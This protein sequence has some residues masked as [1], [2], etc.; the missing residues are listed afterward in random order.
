MTI[1][2]GNSEV[3]NIAIIEPYSAA[4]AGATDYDEKTYYPDWVRPDDW[5]DMPVINSGDNK[6]AILLAVE[7]GAIL[8][9]EVGLMVRGTGNNTLS[10]INWGDGNTTQVEK[11]SA[12]DNS[13]TYHTY[14]FNDLPSSTEIQFRDTVARQ[15]IIEIDNSASGLHWLWLDQMNDGSISSNQYNTMLD[16]YVDG[17]DVRHVRMG[18][19]QSRFLKRLEI[20]CGDGTIDENPFQHLEDLRVAYLPSGA[21]SHR[22][23]INNFFKGCYTLESAPMLD[24]SSCTSTQGIFWDCR[25]LRSVP[26]YDTSNSTNFYTCFYG[27]WSLKNI[28]N[29]DFS[30][31][32]NF[33]YIFRDC[34]D[35]K[36]V[37]YGI[38]WPTGTYNLSR[39]F[40]GCSELVYVANDF[41]ISGATNLEE[42]F[43]SCISLKSVPDIYAP[44]ATSMR[45]AF[46]RCQSLQKINLKDISSVTNMYYC[47][48]DC[49][50][51]IEVKGGNMPTGVTNYFALFHE[52]PKIVKT[53]EFPTPNAT[54]ISYMFN[55]CTNLETTQTFDMSNVVDMYNLYAGCVKIKNDNLKFI[56]FNTKVNRAQNAFNGCYALTSIPSGLFRDYN[57]CPSTTSSMFV[58]CRGIREV[59]DVVLSGCVNA[60]SSSPLY[61]GDNT[62]SFE[63]FGNLAIGSG[64]YLNDILR[65]NVNITHVPAL[66][67]SGVEQL[68]NY[69]F[70]NCRSLIWSDVQGTKCSVSYQ[71]CSLGSGAIENIFNNLANGVVGQSIRLTGNYGTSQLHP[72]TIAIATSKGWTVTT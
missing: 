19:S 54:D 56:N 63:K 59:G 48:H 22:T 8:Q 11:Q 52:C 50:E 14:N 64:V 4:D 9:K 40:A 35:L 6:V 28:P 25:N 5:L 10:T 31:S 15:V 45:N 41:P 46:V 43:S 38:S 37:P 18:G 51:L 23:N 71:N 27:C 1:K 39:C 33:D 29:W 69:T 17:P 16:V 32:T 20:H 21:V 24:T 62:F 72:D 44:N 49:E 60:G 67:F 58:N 13:Y 34:K 61:F 36:Y 65:H 26:D 42:S 57:S 12:G 3:E 47:F 70:Y 30:R 2:I 7:S 68:G 55:G 53:P 66:D